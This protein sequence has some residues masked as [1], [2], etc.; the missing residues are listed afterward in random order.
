MACDARPVMR[1]PSDPTSYIVNPFTVLPDTCG[2]TNAT[3]SD[4]RDGS[5]CLIHGCCRVD[6]RSFPCNCGTIVAYHR[7]APAGAPT[8]YTAEATKAPPS[9]G[10]WRTL[11]SLDDISDPEALAEPTSSEAL[12]IA[13]RGFQ[14]AIAQLEPMARGL[15][16]ASRMKDLE[17]QKLKNGTPY[18]GQAQSAAAAALAHKELERLAIMA[19]DVQTAYY[20]WMHMNQKFEQLEYGKV[21]AVEMSA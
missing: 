20:T 8:A 14:Y 16:A 7:Y 2:S 13:R 6:I 3:D 5:Q 11:L 15:R 17:E 4:L 12:R 19:K 9:R 1:H 10:V 18:E 21:F